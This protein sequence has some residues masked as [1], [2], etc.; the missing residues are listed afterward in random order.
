[1]FEVIFY[2]IIDE[3]TCVSEL[4][5]AIEKEDEGM[6][7]E[8]E[9]VQ[10]V[11]D[12]KGD[13]LAA[14]ALITDYLPFIKAQ[15]SKVMKR[16]VDVTQED[17]LSIGM[18]AFHEAI[19]A[20]SK[21]RGNFLAYASL[22]IRNRII[23]YWRKNDR[24]NKV[25]SLDTPASEDESSKLDYIPD[26]GASHDESLVVREATKD[27]IIELSAQMEEF[28]VSLTDVS[29]NSPKQDRTLKACQRVVAYA[30]DE[31]E[32]MED[33]LRT[34]RLPLA[35][36]VKQTKVARKTIE[37]HRKYIIALLLIYSNGY[38]IIRGHLTEVMKG[39]T[40]E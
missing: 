38:E 27:E 14:D 25:V 36:L 15:V 23:D 6:S 3:V 26:S 30:K 21:T 17:E 12:A 39:V 7:E 8:H 33:F 9:I 4:K 28:G 32:L 5:Y 34:K 16:S 10:R 35:E 22:L 37:R 40:A 24:H 2:V 29:D 31:E 11:Y 1:M 20:Y 13:M 18:I 19:N